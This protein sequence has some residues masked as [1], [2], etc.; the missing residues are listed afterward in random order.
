MATVKKGKSSAS[1]PEELRDM[2]W[3]AAD[4]LRGSMN[5]ADYMNFVL[6]LKFLILLIHFQSDH[7]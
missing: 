2:M 5:A 1:T 7:L 4:K 3:A 6:V